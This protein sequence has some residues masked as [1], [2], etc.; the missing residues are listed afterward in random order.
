MSFM[1]CSIRLDI[2]GRL[3]AYCICLFDTKLLGYNS[4]QHRQEYKSTQALA[5]TETRKIY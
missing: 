5:K 1:I 2:L 4:N 3:T